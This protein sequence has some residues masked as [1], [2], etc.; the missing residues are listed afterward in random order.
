MHIPPPLWFAVTFLAG[1][2]LQSLAPITIH[3]PTIVGIGHAIGF[4]LLVSGALLALS[5]LGLFFLARTTFI[6]HAKSSSL[7]TRGPY[8]FSR[9][10]MYLSLILVYLGF[11]GSFVQPW[12]LILLPIPLAIVNWIVIPFEEAQLRKAFGS[13]YEEYCAKVRRWI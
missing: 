4:A 1:W 8:R 2:G 10:P 9:N 5:C 6:P 12:S 11:V 7:V 13:V 3:S